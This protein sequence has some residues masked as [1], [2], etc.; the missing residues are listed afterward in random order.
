MKGANLSWARMEGADLSEARMEEADLSW[1]RFSEATSF[2]ATSLRSAALKGVDL[3]ML[4]LTQEQIDATFGDASV[5]PLPDGLARPPH[6]PVWDLPFLDDHNFYSEW[7]KWQA[8][9]DGYVPQPPP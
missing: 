4:T 1:A 3:S 6:W 5:T 2:R 9:P 7:R 8:D